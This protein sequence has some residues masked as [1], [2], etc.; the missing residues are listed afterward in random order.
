MTSLTTFVT[1]VRRLA[2]LADPVSVD[3][4]RRPLNKPCNDWVPWLESA[5]EPLLESTLQSSDHALYLV[6]GFLNHSIGLTLLWRAVLDHCGRVPATLDSVLQGLASRLTISLEDYLAV[7]HRPDV[8]EHCLSEVVTVF[9]IDSAL[10]LDHMRERH[11]GRVV[12][13]DKH[14]AGLVLLSLSHET[15]IP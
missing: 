2:I 13:E 5:S 7:A 3:E 10:A 4:G 6:N 9:L 8:L 15:E 14:G 12:S 1:L 11:S